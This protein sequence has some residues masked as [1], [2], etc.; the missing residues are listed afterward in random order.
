[1]TTSTASSRDWKLP[2]SAYNEAI[3][4]LEDEGIDSGRKTIGA[5]KKRRHAREEGEKTGSRGAVLC[6]DLS[7]AFIEVYPVKTLED[8]DLRIYGNGVY[9]T[10]K[11]KYTA[12]NLMIEVAGEM[13]LILTPTQI[14]DALEMIKSKTPSEATE[15]PVNLI[16]VF[17]GVL[18]LDTMELEEYTPTKV[19]LSKYPINYNPDAGKP[20]RFME[21]IR[22][23]FAGVEEQ[24]PLIQEIFG[25]CFLRNYFIEA[26]FFFVGNGGNGKTLLL[27]I[28][29]ALLG[30][31]EHCSYLTF[32]ELSE[33]KNENM[34]YDLFGKSANICGDTGKQKLKETDILKKAT[35]NDWIRARR[36]YKEKFDFKNY[37]KI[38]LSFNKLPEVDDFSDGFK[39][40]LRIVEF[41]NQFKEGVEGTNKNLDREIIENGEMDGVFLWALE[42]L[43]R[44]MKTN[45]LSNTTSTALR[46]L[47]YARK[48]TPM[49]FFVRECIEEA[50]NGFVRKSELLEHYMKYA[51]F[52]RLPQ[53]TVQEFKRE[54]IKECKE[55]GIETGE[56]KSRRYPDRPYGFFNIKV[57]MEALAAHTGQVF[58]PSAIEGEI[59]EQ[60]RFKL[61]T[62]TND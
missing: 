9:Q 31:S 19:F 37:A 14:K 54:L 23:T 44:L 51:A 61:F 12:N 25:Y 3:K 24:I 34:L 32:K 7:E 15:T 21:M 29:S 56:K 5:T 43:K 1:M 53:L 46:G 39:R 33:P 50:E 2:T 22:T 35:G 57:D 60:A 36:L 4:S 30:G 28:L 20:S 26:L 55:I 59:G 8:G 48:S 17:N 47:E 42:G 52:N 62:R 27:N 41:P 40:R 10:C 45:T 58:T 18:N 38:I 11:N 6:D 16:P 13:G 49:Y